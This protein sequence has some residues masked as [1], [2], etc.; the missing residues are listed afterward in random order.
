VKS[1]GSSQWE[2]YLGL[3]AS[4]V[5]AAITK[6]W[7]RSIGEGERFKQ[8]VI[9]SGP[10]RI[11]SEGWRESRTDSCLSKPESGWVMHA[12]SFTGPSP[13]SKQGDSVF[14]RDEDEIY[15]PT[16]KDPATAPGSDPKKGLRNDPRLLITCSLK[17][18]FS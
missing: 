12:P 8:Y 10:D 13:S 16:S 14:R 3:V 2:D 18:S 4:I 15:P 7:A 1:F 11:P 9:K 17:V 6:S 5:D